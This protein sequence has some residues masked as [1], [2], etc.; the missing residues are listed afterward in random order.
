MNTTNISE[1][2]DEILNSCGGSK[3]LHVG[4]DSG[5]LVNSLLS[6]GMDAYGITSTVE[7]AEYNNS[8][9]QGRFSHANILNL[10]YP[11]KAFDTSVITFS[12]EN[13]SHDDLPKAIAEI[14]RVT[15]RSVYLRIQTIAHGEDHLSVIQDRRAWEM[16]FF[17]A[18]FR[19]HPSYY[20]I[21][22]YESL[23][24]E[25]EEITILLE[26]IPSEAY[27]RYPLEALKEERDLHMD[28]TREA[29]ERSDAHI[30]RYQWAATFVRP[31]DTVLDAACGLG[32][33]SYLIQCGTTAEKTIG[34]DGSDYA[35]DYAHHNFAGSVKNLSFQTGMLPE[36]LKAIPDHSVDVVISF[37][38]LEHVPDPE[39]LLAEFHRVLTPA[40]RI[41]VSV[42]NDWSDE[43]GEDPNPFHLHIYDLDKL[44]NQIKINFELEQIVVQSATQYKNGLGSKQWLPARRELYNIATDTES[45]SAPK[46][47]WWLA[48][49]M[50]PIL[51][52]DNIPYCETQFKTFDNQFWNVTNFSKDYKNPWLIRGLVDIGHRLKDKKLLSKLADTVTRQYQENSAD[53]G[54]ALC[55]LGYQLLSSVQSV[56]TNEIVE[57]TNKAKS[58]IDQSTDTPHA[59]RWKVSLSFV[60]GKLWLKAGQHDKAKEALLKCVELDPLVFS[61]LLANRTIEAFLLLGVLAINTGDKGAASNFW[62]QGI[63]LANKAVTADWRSS[64]GDM[65]EPV[66]FGLPELASI[67]DY[68]STCAYALVNIDDFSNKPWWWLQLRRSRN[69]QASMLERK[70]NALHV[71]GEEVNKLNEVLVAKDIAISEISNLNQYNTNILTK[72]QAELGEKETII[73]QLQESL[74]KKEAMP[75]GIEKELV[76]KNQLLKETELSCEYKDKII[77]EL[78][79]FHENKNKIINELSNTLASKEN[80][81]HEYTGMLD[82]LNKV[83]SEANAALEAK[84]KIIDELNASLNEKEAFTQE[85]SHSLSERE[86]AFD[87]LQKELNRKEMLINELS[88]NISNLNEQLNS[89]LIRLRNV[90]AQPWS[91]RK[92]LHLSY[93]LTSLA[94]PLGIR[95]SLAPVVSRL[96]AKYATRPASVVEVEQN[97]AETGYR[98]Q[99]PLVKENAPKVAHVIAN[100]MTGGSSRLVVD[101]IEYLGND[102]KQSIITSYIP[103]PPAY[104]GV[105]IE[106]CRFP[107]DSAPFIEYYQ[108]H[109]PNFIHVHYWGDVDEPWYAK[110]IEAARILGIPV[111]ENINTPIAPHV[112]D[113]VNRYVYVSDYVRHVF[114]QDNDA[115]VTIYPG[116]DFTRFMRNDSEVVPKDCIGMVY[117]LEGDKLNEKAIEPFIR[118][119]QKRPQTKVLIVGGGS[120]LV[121]FQEA[122]KAAGVEANFEFTGYV[123]YDELPGLYRR[124]SLFIAP[125][126]KESFGQVSPFAMNMRVPVIGYDVGAISEIVNSKA[127]LAP[128]GDAEALSDIAV[129]L[130]DND[131]TR[132]QLGKEHQLRA[133]DHFSVQAMISSYSHLYADVVNDKVK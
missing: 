114:G 49:G 21:N 59:F 109:A 133:R 107:V 75:L 31:G 99:V 61:P 128:A 3:F 97:N 90:A 94:T 125:V 113:A 23:G 60:V 130:L 8:L 29:G 132:N 74:T 13:L 78:N 68:A 51:E 77:Q 102:Y 17:N 98:V 124:M 41:I 80:L 96:R 4:D 15:R 66:E 131:A 47:E 73:S 20:L 48:V 54:A 81:I 58:F 63:R 25:G 106:E 19:K 56:D 12:L 18:G 122:V 117:R 104:I 93:L 10:P 123:K 55:V 118:T 89:R 36:A 83:N 115:H 26:K 43:T 86:A 91:I 44:R 45:V 69:S 62:R 52:G 116:S 129:K 33:G 101:L 30:A 111:I 72:L 6:L 119:V 88:N 112:S 121:P 100:F 40:G 103:D 79:R 53:V 82:N 84:S 5:L 70:L 105:D 11:D 7:A 38:T 110:A 14:Y 57:F 87:V 24:R 64:L 50:R 120:L 67:L 92:T 42:P 32:Y 108:R 1:L 37:E 95:R 127:M 71:L 39:G 35:I 126:W 16:S 46:A 9:M 2:T 27:K 65:N 34:I 28:M 85:I 76:I 22:G